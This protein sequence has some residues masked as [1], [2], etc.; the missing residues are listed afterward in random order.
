MIY[1][2]GR[3]FFMMTF[4]KTLKTFKVN[5]NC[6]GLTRAGEW[7]S[8]V[9][10]LRTKRKKGTTKSRACNSDFT[11]RYS[12]L[13]WSQHS[14]LPFMLMSVW[15]VDAASSLLPKT[16]FVYG[17]TERSTWHGPLQQLLSRETVRRLVTVNT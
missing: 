15:I 4:L 6:A 8:E 1:E 16:K 9:T 17:N 3:H 13:I 2:S 7:S 10:A 12:F 5:R 11:K 14:F